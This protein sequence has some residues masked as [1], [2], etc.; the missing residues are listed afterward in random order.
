MYDF[1]SL[2]FGAVSFSGEIDFPCRSMLIFFVVHCCV[3]K[4]QILAA[5]L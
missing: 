2:V 3:G 1:G 5:H 4:P